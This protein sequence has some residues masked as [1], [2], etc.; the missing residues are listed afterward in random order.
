MEELY[1]PKTLGALIQRTPD[2]PSF[3]KD[4]FFTQMQTFT[5]ET[6]SFDIKK[7]RRAITPFVHPDAAAPLTERNGYITRTYTPVM[8]K[9]KRALRVKD[10]KSRAPG[11]NPYNSGMTP[12]KREAALLADDTK[13][14]KDNIIRSQEVMAAD[15]L[16]TGQLHIVGEKINDTIDF[17]FTN[18][19]TLS[20]GQRWNEATGD[21]LDDLAR[22]QLKCRK[23]TGFNPNTLIADSQ[24]LEYLYKNERFLKLLDNRNTDIGRL[25][26][27]NLGKGVI[28]HGFIGGPLGINLYSYDNW[29]VDPA[30]GKEKPLVPEKTV[31]LIPDDAQFSRLYG[32]ITLLTEAGNYKTYDAEY[33]LRAR[34]QMD[35]DVKFLEIMSRPL[36]VPW[37]VDSYYIATVL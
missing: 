25:Q 20:S 33:I 15:L 8:K 30:D 18:K 37:D 3:L 6:I 24:T 13:E 23:A 10:L 12:A 4:K 5:T 21:F 32:G 9:E 1:T 17:G 2:L 28:Y 7:G 29:Y 22:W 34:D 16:F 35:P 26:A 27:Q 31:C 36:F 11:E 14:L 19:E